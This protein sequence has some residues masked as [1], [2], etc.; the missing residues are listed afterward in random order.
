MDWS[1][2]T[3]EVLLTR[4]TRC[5][6]LLCLGAC[7]AQGVDTGEDAGA[8]SATG[9]S[10]VAVIWSF[11]FARVD[12]QGHTAGFDLDN[13][14]STEGGNSGC[15]VPD[16]IGLDGS[17]G[18]DNALGNLIPILELTEATA[19]EDLI[20]DGIRSGDLLMLIELLGIDDI[21]Q[22]PCVD[23]NLLRGLGDPLLSTQ[24]EILAGQTFARD[25]DNPSDVLEGLSMHCGTIEGRPIRLSLP[26]SVLGV[27]LDVVLSNGAIRSSLNEDGSM[28]GTIG[29]GLDVAY[30]LEV[31]NHPNVNPEVA[32]LLEQL[33]DIHADLDLDGDGICE[34]IS[35]SL[36]FEAAQAYLID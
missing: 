19:A 36:A 25:P 2:A 26:F 31:A 10:A 23:L 12:E 3:P 22:D 35:A 16:L 34:Q 11:G 5:L 4:L 6:A 32:T 13:E 14:I 29:A 33:L 1:A 28:S 17:P 24:N 8:C 15:G 30:L 9:S 21:E 18:V 20:E 7:T 27:E